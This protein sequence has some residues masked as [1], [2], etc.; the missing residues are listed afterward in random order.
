MFW[1]KNALAVLYWLFK[2]ARKLSDGNRLLADAGS[3]AGRRNSTARSRP[4]VSSTSISSL[5][6]GG[7]AFVGADEVADS[8]IVT[9]LCDKEAVGATLDSAEDDWVCNHA[10]GLDVGHLHFIEDSLHRRL[11]DLLHHVGRRQVRV[12]AY[13][14]EGERVV[15]KLVGRAVIQ[16]ILKRLDLFSPNKA[17]VLIGNC[18][19]TGAIG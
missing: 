8:D 15:A 6:C 19:P 9:P 5:S 16:P 17:V 2:R 14:R 12:G 7:S 4:A 3:D 11:R 1:P 18:E 13:R 10:D